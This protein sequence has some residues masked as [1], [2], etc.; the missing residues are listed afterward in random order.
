MC[1]MWLWLRARREPILKIDIFQNV[2][3]RNRLYGVKENEKLWCCRCRLSR[4]CH[5][6]DAANGRQWKNNSYFLFVYFYWFVLLF[7]EF[8]CEN[9]RTLFCTCVTT[10]CI[11]ID[12]T[13]QCML[14]YVCDNTSEIGSSINEFVFASN[15]KPN[16]NRAENNAYTPR[17]NHSITHSEKNEKKNPNSNRNNSLRSS[18]VPMSIPYIH[19][20]KN[21]FRFP[22]KEKSK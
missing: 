8:E 9:F 17:I 2:D 5:C 19:Q 12:R 21:P 16:A 22:L 13:S 14:H 6:R 7:V 3:P 18:I 4:H 11:F 10:F 1:T 15:A 20:L